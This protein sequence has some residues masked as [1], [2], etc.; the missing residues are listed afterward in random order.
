MNHHPLLFLDKN[1]R[2]G[3]SALQSKLSE[4]FTTNYIFQSI[5]TAPTNPSYLPEILPL[6]LSQVRQLLFKS[7]DLVGLVITPLITSFCTFRLFSRSKGSKSSK[8][9]AYNPFLEVLTVHGNELRLIGDKAF[10]RTRYVASDIA[11]A[12]CL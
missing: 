7:L 1:Q 3:F 4:F 9:I 8:T 10:S 12:V 5:P 6:P 2:G 11:A